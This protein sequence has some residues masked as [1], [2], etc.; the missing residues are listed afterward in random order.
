MADICKSLNYYPAGDC[1]VQQCLFVS[2]CEPDYPVG[3]ATVRGYF[4][5]VT[6]TSFGDDT[7][8]CDSFVIVDGAQELIRSYLSLI[9]SGNGINSKNE[10]NQPIISLDL[11][12]IDAKDKQKI[13][14][15][16]KDKHIDLL[17]LSPIPPGM[18]VPACYSPVQIIKVN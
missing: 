10:L 4:T 15:S 8:L 13:M 16:T 9:E 14:A 3:I 18:G 7:K 11:N 12:E 1:R 6:K 5:Q 2:P 17:L